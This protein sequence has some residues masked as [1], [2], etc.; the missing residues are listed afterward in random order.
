MTLFLGATVA[1]ANACQ[2]GD[3]KT[4]QVERTVTRVVQ[5][6]GSRCIQLQVVDGKVTATLDGKPLDPSRVRKTDAGFEILAEDGSVMQALTVKTDAGGQGVQRQRMVVIEE[7]ESEDEDENNLETDMQFAIARASSPVMIGVQLSEVDEALGAKLSIDPSKATLLMGVMDGLP[8]A[9]AGVQKLDV[10]VGVGDG[11]DGSI[12]A[13]R[14]A[15]ATMKPGETVQLK[16]RRGDEALTKS[17]VVAETDAVAMGAPQE[18]SF[19]IAMD[20]EDGEDGEDGASVHAEAHAIFIGPDGK[21]IEMQL[22][23]GAKLPRGMKMPKGMK[24][25]QGMMRMPMHGKSVQ[26]FA[27]DPQEVEELESM[28]QAAASQL[29]GDDFDRAMMS[30]S[31][32]MN[33]AKALERIEKLEADVKR[34]TEELAKHD[35]APATH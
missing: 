28:M 14:A 7:Q 34:L 13:I 1:T 18:F 32:M 19:E 17:I 12:E 10:V 27:L 26:G 21:P 15:L 9:K 24:M 8:A 23:A 4:A 11:N 25:P 31:M 16:I 29:D 20:G 35:A 3:A 6:D 5:Q 22:P 30:G 33:L 2:S